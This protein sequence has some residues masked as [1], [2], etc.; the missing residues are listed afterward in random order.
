MAL[1]LTEE[2]IDGLLDFPSV[3]EGV[4][5]ILAAQAGGEATNRARRRV[6][7]PTGSLNVMFAAAPTLGLTGLKAYT[8][9]KGGA[10][11]YA[12]VFSAE[13]GELLS[14]M[15]AARL[16]SI[17]TGAASA[18]ATKHLARE[19]ASTL[20]IYGAGGQA[21]T[22]LEAIAA[23]RELSRVIV[24]SRREESRKAF[25]EKM[26]EKLG[27]EIETTHAPEEPAAQDIV[28][29]ITSAREP[30]LLGEWLKDGAHV[31][32]AG[33]NMLSKAEIDREVVRKARFVCVDSREEIGLEAGNLQPALDTGALIPE[34]VREL[35]E[36]VA[37]QV[38]GRTSPEDI[39][40]F[41]SQG[42]AL[43]D[44]AAARL[45]YDRAKERGVGR[46]V[47]F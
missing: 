41:S 35:G 42:I 20:G 40:L 1:F 19:D 22:Q 33:V 13:T 43:E 37:G 5:G 24:H 27:M 18:V 16:G 3:I 44:L 39:T 45:A 46:E 17:R 15:Q 38:E 21:E 11:F 36:V 2:E 34:A 7:L 4:E 26:G 25:A 31:N 47:D 14:V 30:V 6:A 10:R 12:M 8:A 32:A 9:T 23:V 29:T 28:V